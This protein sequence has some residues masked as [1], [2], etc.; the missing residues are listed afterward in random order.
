MPIQNVIINSTDVA[1]SVEFYTR[2]LEAEVVGE[3][4]AGRAVLDLVTATLELRA[5]P[6]GESTWVPDDLQLGFRRVGFKVERV[7][8][9]AA[10]LT[11][12]DVPSTSTRWTPRAASGSA[13]STTRTGRCS[14]WSRATCSTPRCSTRLGW[15]PSALSVCPTD[16]ASTTS[17]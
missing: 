3:P 1:A 13:S 4:N 10:A 8:P 15:P 14:S 5:V 16:P 12:A 6:G 9:R 17:P 2:F 11:E 7:D